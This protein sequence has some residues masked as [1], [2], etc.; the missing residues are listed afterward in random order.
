MTRFRNILRGGRGP[1]ARQRLLDHYE[2]VGQG[3]N[4]G[5]RGN[6]PA[7]VPLFVVPFGAAFPAGLFARVSS[8]E[9]AWAALGPLAPIAARARATLVAETTGLKLR[10]L[11]AARVVR[12][13]KT[14]T[15]GTAT[16]S[17]LTGL[18]YLR[19]N[20][21]SIS[22]PFGRD[23]ATDT[24]LAARSAITTAISNQWAVTFIDEEI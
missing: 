6:R 20:N 14:D 15:T 12:R 23:N 5:T 1:A 24:L 21:P 18:R 13:A 19:Y 16:T 22:V 17:R 11:K 7:S 4:V 2:G 10:G 8:T 9:P 3:Q